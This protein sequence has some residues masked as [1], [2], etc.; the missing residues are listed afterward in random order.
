MQTSASNKET[1]IIILALRIEK[2]GWIVL[3]PVAVL[4]TVYIKV[5]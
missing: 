5:P 3:F 2:N 1:I 4:L